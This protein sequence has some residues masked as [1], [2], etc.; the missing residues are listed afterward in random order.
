MDGLYVIPEHRNKGLGKM[1]WKSVVKVGTYFIYIHESYFSPYVDVQAGLERG[2]TR[3]NWS[4]C[5]W[6]KPSIEFYKAF[7]AVYLPTKE[8]WLSFRMDKKTM[9]DFVC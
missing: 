2:C 3:C 9:E 7:G 5:N 1:L 6:N 8:G 4:V